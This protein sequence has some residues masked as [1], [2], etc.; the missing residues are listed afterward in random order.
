MGKR[1][2]DAPPD[3]AGPK[4][5]KK[6]PPTATRCRVRFGKTWRAGAAVITDEELRFNTGRTGRE[7]EDF[8]VHIRFEHITRVAADAATG[9]MTVSSQDGDVVFDLGRLAVAWKD[10]LD[11]TP[12]AL[13]ELGIDRGARVDL[14]AIDDATLTAALEARGVALATTGQVDVLLAGAE[15]RADLARLPQLAARL[16]RGGTLWVVYPEGS[17]NIDDEEI[18]A[19]ARAAGLVD[20]VTVDVSPGRLAV[21]LVPRDPRQT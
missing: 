14:V 20:G 10:L 15:H 1:S 13:R 12:D 19:A 17:R 9:L 4:R 8:A 18:A 6:P 21:K 11:K 2:P 16:R 7:G 5:G 3:V